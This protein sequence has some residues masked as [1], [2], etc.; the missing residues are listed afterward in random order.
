MSDKV[1]DIRKQVEARKKEEADQLDPIVPDP[2]K[3]G[4]GGPDDPRF[5]LDCLDANERGDGVMF[6]ALNRN[7]F[8]FDKS[9]QRWLEFPTDGHHWQLDKMGRSITAVEKVALKYQERSAFLTAEINDISDRLAD[10]KA[11]VKTAKA[12]DDDVARNNAETLAAKLSGEISRLTSKRKSLNRRVDR[13]RGENGAK[14]ALFWSHSIENPLAILGDQVDQNPML[15]ACGNGVIDL[16]TG[17]LRK[18]NPSDWL[19]KASPTCLPDNIEHYLA[20]GNNCPCPD[21]DKTI[22]EILGDE[23]IAHFFHRLL[24]YSITGLVTEHVVT[25]A[26]GEGRNGKGTIFELLMK[27]VGDFAWTISPELI[28]EQ[29]NARASSGAAAD[30]VAID[31][32][33]IIVSA[34][35][36]ENRKISGSAYKQLSGGDTIKARPLYQADEINIT[37][38]WKLFIHSNH[39]PRGLTKD[40]ALLQR[41]VYIKFPFLYVDNPE[42]EARIKPALA[43]QFRIKDRGLPLR[44]EKEAPGILAWL[45]RGALLWQRQGLKPPDKIKADV[46]E[47]RVDEDVLGQFVEQRCIRTPDDPH[48]EILL[49][50]FYSVF[51]E[52]HEDNHGDYVP[53]RKT[54]ASELVKRGYKKDTRGGNVH[55]YGLRI[56]D[57]TDVG[58]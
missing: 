49:K 30:L 16:E 57:Y 53:A 37:P 45:V 48:S 11:S 4:S 3:K 20:T 7:Q 43:E 44:L 54:I 47:L 9:D 18:G 39:I 13:L 46:D 58:Y 31:G 19:V 35:T 10:A 27:I 36:D 55:I 6:A 21:W 32:R 17:H 41:L 33:R 50:Q 51:K 8:V 15:M 40:F 28:L 34:E 26:I 24:G 22:V 42:F 1:V 56:R 52:W 2:K 14:K 29:K 25:V 23:E 38:T 12:K 5:V